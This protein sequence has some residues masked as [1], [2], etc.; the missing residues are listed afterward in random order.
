MLRKILAP[1]L[2]LIPYLKPLKMIIPHNL[3]LSFQAESHARHMKNAKFNVVNIHAKGKNIVETGVPKE[4]GSISVRNYLSIHNP[5]TSSKPPRAVT[6]RPLSINQ[7]HRDSLP[8]TAGLIL[9]LASHSTLIM[10]ENTD[11]NIMGDASNLQVQILVMI[12]VFGGGILCINFG[13]ALL[14]SDS[15]QAIKL[16]NE[17]NLDRDLF[18]LVQAISSLRCRSWYTEFIWVPREGNMYADGMAKLPI[19]QNYEL[20]FFRTTPIT[21]VPLLERDILGPSYLK[22]SASY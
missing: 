9:N 14:T 17:A 11:P 2:I 1:V 13:L 7:T 20:L 16:F 6:C 15:R 21:I 8:D 5:L 3:L 10:P 18:P 12:D 4:R 19:V 22:A